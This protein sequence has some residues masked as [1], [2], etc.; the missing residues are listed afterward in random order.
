MG[1]VGAPGLRPRRAETRG[2]PPPAGLGK[3]PPRGLR[4]S[5][6]QPTATL[7][8]SLAPSASPPRPQRARACGGTVLPRTSP[9][10][11]RPERDGGDHAG[12]AR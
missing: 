6:G 10:G 3:P 5:R 12:A 1:A 8:V 11:N 7:N 4:A 2:A 9:P